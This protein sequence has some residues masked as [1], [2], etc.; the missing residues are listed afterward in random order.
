MINFKDETALK[1]K[2]RKLMFLNHENEIFYIVFYE[3][4]NGE[5][6]L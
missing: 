6:G 1:I 4:P 2:Y 5:V 3:K